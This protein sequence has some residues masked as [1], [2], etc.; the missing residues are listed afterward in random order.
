[1]NFFT[2]YCKYLLATILIANTNLLANNILPNITITSMANGNWDSPTTWIGGVVPNAIN[3]S[4]IVINNE[5]T[6]VAN[7]SIACNLTVNVGAALIINTAINFDVIFEETTTLQTDAVTI[8]G[9][10]ENKGNFYQYG[11]FAAGPNSFLKQTEATATFKMHASNGTAASSIP[12]GDALLTLD[13]TANTEG[14][15]KGL[16]QF[17]EPPFGHYSKTINT[18]DNGSG[19]VVFGPDNSDLD[20]RFG[21]TTTPNTANT[22]GFAIRFGNNFNCRNF[23]I[24][25]GTGTGQIV[26]LYSFSNGTMFCD[27]NIVV[28]NGTLRAS[29]EH[30]IV[31]GNFY[32]RGITAGRNIINNGSIFCKNI[33]IA[34]F[35]SED[36]VF[37]VPDSIGGTG[38]FTNSI[39]YPT[40]NTK[41]I[42]IYTNNPYGVKIGQNNFSCSEIDRKS[43]V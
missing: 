19:G 25:N 13:E 9:T 14:F 32:A 24:D 11:K 2:K 35:A 28:Q 5:V 12:D 31:S 17:F 38:I 21:P 3:C 4:A 26:G 8:L 6:V 29:Y 7:T 16:L 30:S 27:S 41:N 1:M 43:V 33:A 20:I 42:F 18:V 36:P 15:S 34:R 23:V 40:Q 10:F 37:T 22:D 39:I